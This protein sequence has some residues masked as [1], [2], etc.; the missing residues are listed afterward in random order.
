MATKRDVAVVFDVWGQRGWYGCDVAGES[1]HS[2]DIERLFRGKVPDDGATLEVV[3]QLVPEPTNRHDRNA[4]KV[5]VGSSHVGYLPKEV[6]GD[7]SPILRELLAAGY[8][9]QCGAQI[10]AWPEVDYSYDGR[11]NA[12]QRR[13]GIS[14]SVRLDLAEPHMLVPLN[15]VPVLAHAILPI[16]TAVQVTGEETHMTTL[17]AWTRAA[18]EGWVHVT[19]HRVIEQLARSTR[20]VVEVRLDGEPVG[21]LTPK[22]SGE[23]S[24][25]I[26]LLDSS[27]VLT[28]A[29]AVVKGNTLKVD[30]VLY[31]AKAGQLGD[32]WIRAAVGAAPAT[33]QVSAREPEAQAASAVEPAADW[34]QVERAVSTPRVTAQLPPAGWFPNPSGGEG[35]QWWDGTA[36]TEHHA[37]GA[38]SSPALTYASGTV[39]GAPTRDES[40]DSSGA[41]T[42]VDGYLIDV[43]YDDRVLRVRGKNGIARLALA[44]PDHANGDV[45]IPR[46]SIAGVT[47]QAANPLVNGNLTVTT[48]EGRTYQ[49]HF[50]R[51]QQAEFERLAHALG[52]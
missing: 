38:P 13:S 43:T 33:A 26:E 46:D 28:V 6:A 35:L 34:P 15:A 21:Q 1:F 2:K 39:G 36:W 51:K 27:G 44:G 10:R 12:Q 11:G 37:P 29:R 50:R 17:R 31:A 41:R 40:P 30:V 49:L 16:G 25:A 45:V 23:Y 8:A 47:F 24:P 48:Y 20:D 18:G 4:V 52:I 3:A 14:S 19:L 5:M 32:D 9:P 7:Y 42:N 22:M